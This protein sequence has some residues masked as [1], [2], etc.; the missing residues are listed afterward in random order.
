[1][2]IRILDVFVVLID[3][4]G[5]LASF[6]YFFKYPHIGFNFE[7]TTGEWQLLQI[8]SNNLSNSGPPLKWK[9]WQFVYNTINFTSSLIQLCRLFQAFHTNH[10]GPVNSFMSFYRKLASSKNFFSTSVNSEAQKKSKVFRKIVYGTLLGSYGY[11]QW[12]H[13]NRNM[14]IAKKLDIPF[15][16]VYQMCIFNFDA[17]CIL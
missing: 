5:K 17:Y 10:P 9:K 16:K 4:F 2:Q 7:R 13:Y 11:Y 3:N 6:N 12:E 8:V 14:E 1:M 15:Y